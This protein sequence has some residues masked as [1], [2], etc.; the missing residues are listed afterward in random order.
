MEICL[1]IQTR[2]QKKISHTT[3]LPSVPTRYNVHN[4]YYIDT[5]VEK[6]YWPDH[7]LPLLIYKLSV[8]KSE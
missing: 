3:S 6:E 2:S 4:M 8:K 7:L 1:L 5:Y